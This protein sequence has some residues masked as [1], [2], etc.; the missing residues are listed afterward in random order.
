MTVTFGLPKVGMYQAPAS[1]H[2]GR[3]QVIDIGIPRSAMEA[4]SLELLTTRWVRAHLPARPEDA[5]KGTFGKVLVVGGSTRY[6]GAVQLA[7]S[8]AYRA[9]AG[10]VTIACPEE[11]LASI[12]PGV[13][14]ATWLPQPAGPDGGLSE[15]AAPG[16]RATWS[17]YSG[18]VFGPGLG[19]TE[20][21]R[22]LTWA[23]L[24]DLADA[25]R[26]AVIDA[27]AL[28]A[29]ATLDDG[30]GRVPANAVLT[31]HPGEMARLM[32]TTVT[33]IQ[34]RRLD[35]AKECAARF[36]CVVVLKGAHSVVAAPDGR[37]SLSPFANP[38]LA[39]AGSGDVLSGMIGGYL[40]QGVE[41][42]AAACL[43]VYLHGAAGEALRTE[44]GDAGLLAG[45]IAARLPGV[46]KDV[47]AP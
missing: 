11:I 17:E 47:A 46:V 25:S 4:V 42:F 39:T 21:T 18:V 36:G 32:K 44:Y 34:G 45:E 27:D 12:A 22:A 37:A 35:V 24:P 9:G 1:G 2:L 14:E 29:L 26:G 31:P 19:N 43:G 30:P 5:N 13:A 16:L 41:P 33:D 15:L 7:A 38:L 28:N 10:L 23:A 40:A 20:S 3:V 6:R 8:A